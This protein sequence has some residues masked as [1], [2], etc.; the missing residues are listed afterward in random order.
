MTASLALFPLIDEDEEP[1]TIA[2][3]R[4]VVAPV[5]AADVD[6]EPYFEIAMEVDE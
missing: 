3:V 2:L 6:A 1:R 5:D 4:Q